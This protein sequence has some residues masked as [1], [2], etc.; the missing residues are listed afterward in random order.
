MTV[1]FTFLE[2]FYQYEESPGQSISKTAEGLKNP[3]IT[4]KWL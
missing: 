2:I 4:V 1:K 3:N